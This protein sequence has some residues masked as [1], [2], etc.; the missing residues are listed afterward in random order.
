MAAYSPPLPCKVDPSLPAL[1]E[2]TCQ[3]CPYD[4]DRSL[5]AVQFQA[6]VNIPGYRTHHRG[7]PK[8]KM[9]SKDNSITE[10][11]IGRFRTVKFV[12][13]LGPARTISRSNGCN[14]HNPLFKP[15]GYDCGGS[16]QD[17]RI[18]MQ[19]CDFALAA[20]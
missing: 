19:L 8:A 9:A 17:E 12:T 18:S 1:F 3:F 11:F 10:S 7:S 5:R 6:Y 14:P 4:I 2:T 20:L 15:R 16:M 13:A